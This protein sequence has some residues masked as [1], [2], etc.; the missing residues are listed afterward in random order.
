MKAEFFT[1]NRKKLAQS[2][3]G[4]L[5]VATAYSKMQRTNNEAFKFEQESNFLYLT[6]ISEPDWWLI[7][8]GNRNKS[9]LVRPDV[10]PYMVIFNGSL[11][12]S[13]AQKIS[14]VNEIISK[15]DALSLLRQL[16]RSHNLVHTVKQPEGLERY[17][18]VLNP[19]LSKMYDLLDRNFEDVQNCRKEMAIIRAIKQPEEIAQ[20]KKAINITRSALEVVRSNISKYEYEYEIEADI[21][22]DFTLAAAEHCFE[23]IVASGK[24][25]CILH[26]TK[27]NTKLRKG[28][29][30]L[31]DIGAKIGQYSADITRSYA[32]GKPTN[33]SKEIYEAVLSA[34]NK[35][36]N[37][38]RPTLLLQ[39]LQH[40]V[41][42]EMSLVIR[43]LKLV[44]DDPL[45]ELPHYFPHAIGHGL[46]VDLHE[47]LA[48]EMLQEG[49][50]ITIEPGIYIPE[51]GIGVRIEDDIL[52]TKSGALNLSAKIPKDLIY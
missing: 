37:K 49:M 2:L 45:T 1:E 46:G 31:V 42:T 16:K 30:I 23:P 14:G 7:Y 24:N 36:I 15:D 20:I 34:Q 41:E 51:E 8:D 21:T 43:E 5:I 44:K 4:G 40:I 12:D 47:P 39:D 6:G 10:D 35:I 9:W 27:N 22:R 11:S 25:A 13:A 3:K 26:Y 19:A 32:F 33:R 38:L 48:H 29:L 17:D 50:V 52:I 28:N 18:F